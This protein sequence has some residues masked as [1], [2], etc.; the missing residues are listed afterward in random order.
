MA[1]DLEAD[2]RKE[3]YVGSIG[4]L[5]VVAIPATIC[6]Y[7]GVCVYVVMRVMY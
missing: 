5:L 1:H 6:L 3:A 2:E 7:V 4:W